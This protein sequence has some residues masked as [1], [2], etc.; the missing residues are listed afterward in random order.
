MAFLRSLKRYRW[1][2]IFG[3][4]VFLAFSFIYLGFLWWSRTWLEAIVYTLALVQVAR[5]NFFDY[6]R[7]NRADRAS[8]ATV[9]TSL[10]AFSAFFLLWRSLTLGTALAPGIILSA[11]LLFIVLSYSWAIYLPKVGTLMNENALLDLKGLQPVKT[12][13]QLLISAEELP[14]PAVLFFYRGDWC[15]YCQGQ[16]TEL[17]QLSSEFAAV[18]LKMVL[19]SPDPPDLMK[20]LSKRFPSTFLL[21]SG[22]PGSDRTFAWHGV[23]F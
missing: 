19:I 23:T 11:L 4:I 3:S 22:T 20:K 6:K 13:D 8:K 21:M 2:V 1:V 7:K 18:G 5:G 17:N 16:I 12:E 15:P 10:L 14:L 9:E